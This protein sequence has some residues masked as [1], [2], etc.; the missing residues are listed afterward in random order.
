MNPLPEIKL[1]IRISGVTTENLFSLDAWFKRK[2]MLGWHPCDSN[3][4]LNLR[5]RISLLTIGMKVINLF[6]GLDSARVCI[7]CDDDNFLWIL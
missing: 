2:Q 6:L 5:P 7:L 4:R 1:R 3:P